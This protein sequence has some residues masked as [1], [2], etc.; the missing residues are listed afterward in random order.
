M[1]KRIII[2][3]HQIQLLKLLVIQLYRMVIPKKLIMVTYLVKQQ[4]ALVH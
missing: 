1:T 3:L 4:E 2:Q